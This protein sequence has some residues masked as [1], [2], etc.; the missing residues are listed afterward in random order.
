MSEHFC[1]R[2]PA[3]ARQPLLGT[4]L[5]SITEYLLVEDHG[6]WG[7]KQPNALALLSELDQRRW[8]ALTKARGRKVLYLRRPKN[9]ATLPQAKRRFWW[10]QL[11]AEAS[12]LLA[13]P[14]M[15]ISQLCD[16]AEAQGGLVQEDGEYRVPDSAGQECPLAKI[17]APEEARPEVS[18]MLLVCT[19]GQRDRC[20]SLE[21]MPLFLALRKMAGLEVWQCSHL[22]GHRFAA[23]VLSL[24]SGYMWGN[25]RAADAEALAR[26]IVDQKLSLPEKVRGLCGLSAPA[27]IADLEFRRRE[28]RWDLRGEPGLGSQAGPR[29]RSAAGSEIE[30]RRRGELEVLGSCGDLQLKR[31]PLYESVEPAKAGEG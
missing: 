7:K 8:P 4:A 14:P 18:P 23:T 31:V 16:R 13:L 12:P 6:P 28:S 15:S 10:L 2:P 25:L 21:G 1:C 26:G 9:P 29:F 20:C 11:R 17:I 24:P 5:A 22:G 30:I 27:Q 3:E 19:H